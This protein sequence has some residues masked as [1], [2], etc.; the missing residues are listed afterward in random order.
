MGL[1]MSYPLVYLGK[2]RK[3]KKFP[4]TKVGVFLGR[5]SFPFP[6]NIKLDNSIYRDTIVVDE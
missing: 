6:Y 2:E 3:I 1:L 5:V 4:P